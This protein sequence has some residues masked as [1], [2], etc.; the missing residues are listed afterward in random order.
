MPAGARGGLTAL[1]VLACVPARPDAHLLGLGPIHAA[2]VERA[3]AGAS[4]RLGH[5][6][7]RRILTDFH[8]AAGVR[9]QDRLDAQG[10]GAADYLKRIVFTDGFAHRGCRQG[11]ALA[12]TSPGSRVV[13]VCGPRFQQA[14]ARR[15]ETA[16]VVVLHEALHTLGLGEDPPTS[17]EITRQVA[18]RCVP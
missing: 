13:H 11:D 5:E 17:L 9:L 4:R 12:L 1:L 18:A 10:V 14:Q 7:C 15:A 3:V 16:E 6:E 8:D 2:V